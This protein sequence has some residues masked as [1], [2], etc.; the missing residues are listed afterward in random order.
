MEDPKVLVTVIV[1]RKDGQKVV[2]SA[3]KAGAPG[4]TYF[5]GRGTG[6][7]QKLGTWAFLIEAEKQV[8][9]MVMPEPQADSVLDAIIKDTG[10]DKPGRGFAFIQ[11]ITR[12]VGFYKETK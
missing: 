8:I 1:Q 2:D 6:V 9:M 7:R 11:P 3:I 5:Y 10:I 4:V 12:V